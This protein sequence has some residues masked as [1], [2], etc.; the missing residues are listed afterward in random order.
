M[1][2]SIMLT[3]YQNPI[4]RAINKTKK[5]NQTYKKYSAQKTKFTVQLNEQQAKQPTKK[6]KKLNSVLT[7]IT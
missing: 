1:L 6:G 7:V 5:S 2:V 3:L 4:R